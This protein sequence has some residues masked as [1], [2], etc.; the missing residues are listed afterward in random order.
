MLWRCLACFIW[1]CC[2]TA[3]TAQQPTPMLQRYTRTERHM[4]VDFTIVLY[5]DNEKL[6]ATAFEQ[7][8]KLIGQLDRIMSDY[9]ADSEL[10]LLSAASPT[11]QPKQVS[12]ELFEVLSAAQEASRKT[13]GA[14][15]ITVGPLTK[16][17]RRARRQKE[18]PEP[19]ELATALKSVGWQHLQLDAQTQTANLKVPHMRLDLGGIGQGF[20]CDKVMHTLKKLGINSALVDASGDILVSDAPPHAAGW[21]VQLA[22]IHGQPNTSH[23]L[24]VSNAAVATSGDAF[25]GV[26]LNGVRYSH[27]VDPAT[28][29]GVR[30]KCSVTVIAPTCTEADILSTSITIT[31][32]EHGF[33]LLEQYPNTHARI[34]RENQEQTITETKTAEF[35]KFI[36]A[37]TSPEPE[38]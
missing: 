33:K 38:K 23:I 21:K 6:A 20:A 12:P 32:L 9:A 31:S 26:E 29:L 11:L 36:Q 35:S 17:W 16:L 10:S 28:G 8:F 7:S 24:L 18:M 27:I 34:L 2:V 5:A 19:M 22:D 3:I 30:D 37:A 1:C 25:R 4:A 13:N 14:F 15:D